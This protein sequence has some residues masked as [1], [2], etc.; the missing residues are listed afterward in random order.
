[1]RWAKAGFLT[2]VKLGGYENTAHSYRYDRR[3][4]QGVRGTLAW[5]IFLVGGSASG[6]LNGLAGG[7]RR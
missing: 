2:A 4:R 3:R 6:M 7:R 1:M 5:V